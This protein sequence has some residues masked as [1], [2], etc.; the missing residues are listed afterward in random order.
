MSTQKQRV[1]TMRTKEKERVYTICSRL[2]NEYKA[3]FAIDLAGLKERTET[4][5]ECLSSWEED[6]EDLIAVSEAL[7]EP[8][9]VP[10]EKVKIELGL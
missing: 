7:K 1:N 2:P 8:G 4:L 5:E 10:W 3:S 6:L 9:W